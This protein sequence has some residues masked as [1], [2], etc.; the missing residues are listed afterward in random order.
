VGSATYNYPLIVGRVMGIHFKMIPGYQ[1]T[2]ADMAMLRE[3]VDGQMGNTDSLRTMLELEGARVLL[4]IARNRPQQFAKTP[5]IS[6]YTTPETRGLVN[7]L[8]ASVELSRPIAAPPN[9]PPGRLKALREAMEKTFK[10][11]ELLDYAR[12][13][14]LPVSYA[15]GEETKTMFVNALHQSPDVI[16]LIKELA[17]PEK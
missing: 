3:E 5:I 12:K 1:G 11:P 14:K 7:F 10:D 15:S 13:I 2:E 9:M 17:Q 6:D 16:K 8:I 4:V